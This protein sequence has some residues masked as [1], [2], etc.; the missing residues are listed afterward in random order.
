[1]SLPAALT[2]RNML[3]EL[4]GRDVTVAQADPVVGAD[5]TKTVMAVY[6]DRNLTL[7]AVLGLDLP[8]AANA[9]AALG[10]LPVGVVE[11]AMKLGTLTAML[12]ENVGEICNVFTGLLNRDGGPHVKLHQLFEPGQLPPADVSANMVAL[13][14]RMDLNVTVARYGGGKLSV[15]LAA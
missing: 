5:L 14:R 13:G 6:V 15:S 7:A 8:L 3:E 1:M 9:G 11:D 4:L 2:V 10:L 12:A